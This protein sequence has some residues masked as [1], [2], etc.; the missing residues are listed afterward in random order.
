M[1]D[2]PQFFDAHSRTINI[3]TNLFLSVI[4][5]LGY[6]LILILYTSPQS[7]HLPSLVNPS[8]S[9]I[10]PATAVTLVTAVLAATTS[11]LV[12]RCVEQSLWRKL[13]PRT[14]TRH[15]T[16]KES[17]S[18]AQWSISPIAHL[19][20]VF[21]GN[22][23]LLKV[24]GILLIA[25]AIVSPVLVSGISLKDSLTTSQTSK[26]HDT[27]IWSGWIDA[28]NKAYNGGNFQD[29]PGIIG[30]LAT[31]SNLSAPASPVCSD[32]KCRVEAIATSIRANCDSSYT[33]YKHSP[34]DIDRYTTICSS[35]NPEICTSLNG[36]YT[37]AN[38][39]S[40]FAPASDHAV[41]NIFSLIAINKISLLKYT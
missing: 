30:A 39:S 29:V 3:I 7:Y 36:V 35:R 24:A 17:R 21:D 9:G 41:I 5:L 14:L 15:L 37:Y 32:P 12:T 8:A 6:I 38:F 27:D 25:I 19:T 18:L 23:W 31:L 20:Y 11:G 26:N 2:L 33:Q 4:A 40:G 1:M 13:S 28:A 10:K 16:V 34:R 22:S